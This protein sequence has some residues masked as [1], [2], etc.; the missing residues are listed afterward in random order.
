MIPEYVRNK[1]RHDEQIVEYLTVATES[2]RLATEYVR[3]IV[4]RYRDDPRILFWEIGN[5]YNLEADLSARWKERPANQIPTSDQ[6]RSFLIQIAMLIKQLDRN[7][8]ITSGNSDMRPYAWHIRHAILSHASP[9][10]FDYK[11]KTRFSLLT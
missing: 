10:T 9:R 1:Y 3:A 8:L 5:E 7:H 4:S 2:N 11:R 6:I